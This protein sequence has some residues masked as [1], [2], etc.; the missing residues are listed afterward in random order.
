MISVQVLLSEERQQLIADIEEL[1]SHYGD[2]SN[3][4]VFNPHILSPSPSDLS[5]IT[6]ASDGLMTFRRL[7]QAIALTFEHSASL[8]NAM[9][10]SSLLQTAVNAYREQGYPMIASACA[11]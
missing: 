4:D 3:P 5:S 8:G 6:R 10:A 7:N 11:F 1:V 2:F 9:V